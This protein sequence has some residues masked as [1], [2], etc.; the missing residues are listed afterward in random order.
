MKN[1][2]K[3]QL[4]TVFTLVITANCFSQNQG[5][6]EQLE[7]IVNG[8]Y[9]KA[10]RAIT[11]I[12]SYDSTKTY[13]TEYKG[14]Q[15]AFTVGMQGSF[16]S[17]NQIN[18]GNRFYV[19]EYFV[20][21]IG[22]GIATGQ[23]VTEGPF[24]IPTRV[25]L[26]ITAGAIVIPDKLV[27]TLKGLFWGGTFY[28]FILEG[29]YTNRRRRLVEATAIINDKFWISANFNPYVKINTDTYFGQSFSKFGGEIR[30][31]T[32]KDEYFGVSFSNPL[33]YEVNQADLKTFGTQSYLKELNI[34]FS[35]IIPM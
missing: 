22:C 30:Y 11:T 34:K 10:T 8:H 33:P 15:F 12:D 14:S 16:L 17:Q 3:Q 5:F 29:Q 26:G 2:F 4:L 19:A 25:S 28:D 23:V 13:T 21:E 1:L 6:S 18:N 31:R 20:A 24:I 7:F 32:K 35:Y 27:V 9:N